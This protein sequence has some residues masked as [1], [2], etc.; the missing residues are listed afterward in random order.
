MPASLDAQSTGT[1]TGDL[2]GRVTDEKGLA[3]P[4]ARLTAI[5]RETGASRSAICDSSGA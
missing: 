1:T 4:G 5:H 3:L 2:K